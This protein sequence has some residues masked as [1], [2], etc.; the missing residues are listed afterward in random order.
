MAAAEQTQDLAWL[1]QHTAHRLRGAADRIALDHGL[2]GGF[3][4]YALLMVLELQKPQTQV[5]LGL[6]VGLDKTTLTATLDRMEAADLV[7]RK[8]NPAN[9]RVRT[10]VTT[11]KG[12]KLLNAVTAARRASEEVP[13]MKASELKT[14]R[15]LLQKLDTACEAAGMNS[16]GSCV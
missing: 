11:A 16:P 13:G 12:R 4:D 14:L 9:R 8:L 10:P 15:E 3:R 1:L 7:E 6:H 2:S 5:E